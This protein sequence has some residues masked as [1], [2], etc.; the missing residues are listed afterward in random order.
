METNTAYKPVG[1]KDLRIRISERIQTLDLRTII[2][3]RKQIRE[4]RDL[5]MLLNDSKKSQD[6]RAMLN[7]TKQLIKNN[8]LRNLIKSKSLQK[9]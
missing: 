5:R 9:K 1:N 2:N 3:I 6:L 7:Y 4:T 8:D